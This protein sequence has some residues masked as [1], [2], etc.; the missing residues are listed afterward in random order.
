MFGF[1]I[2]RRREFSS[3]DLCSFGYTRDVDCAEED[4]GFS[5][6]ILIASCRLETGLL[7]HGIGNPLDN[8]WIARCSTD[9]IDGS[10]PIP[11]YF[12][13]GDKFSFFRKARAN[14]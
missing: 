10:T 13:G 14:S 6:R 12:E 3:I 2:S 4:D 11:V 9:L 7:G 8:R 1:Q 5:A